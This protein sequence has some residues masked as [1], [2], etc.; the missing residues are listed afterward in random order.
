MQNGAA[1]GTSVDPNV[2]AFLDLIAWSEGTSRSTLTQNN[3]YDV[4]VSGVN[5]PSIFTSYADHPF[6]GGRAPVV[7]RA[8]P[9]LSSTASGRYQ[10]L[11]HWWAPYKTMLNLPDFSPASQDAV[12]IQQIRERQALAMIESGDIEGAIAACSNIWASL[13]GNNYGQAG[14]HTMAALLTQYNTLSGSPAG[15]G[16]QVTA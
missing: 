8:E 12:A 3:G 7:V 16:E 5:G 2:K 1:M 4:I 6:A 14:G 11:L 9:P 10:L 13:P 15:A